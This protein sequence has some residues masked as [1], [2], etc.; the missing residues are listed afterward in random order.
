MCILLNTFILML[1]WYRQTT[2]VENSLEVL[3]IVFT[4]MFCLEAVI[5][6]TAIGF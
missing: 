3:N 6:I 5:R 2:V 4:I 1:K